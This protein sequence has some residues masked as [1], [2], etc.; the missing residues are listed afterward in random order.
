M[1]TSFL[2]VVRFRWS[3][4]SGWFIWTLLHTLI[5]YSFTNAWKIAVIDSL[6]S[7]GLLFLTC[8]LLMNT[9]RYYVPQSNR[10]FTLL[11][12]TLVLTIIWLFISRFI[13]LLLV[14]QKG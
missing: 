6:G 1:S 3:F 14:Q 4:F 8:L 12:W 5:I 9:L 13:I 7:N 2:S 11:A 10:Y